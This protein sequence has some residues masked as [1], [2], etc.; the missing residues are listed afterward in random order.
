M[1]QTPKSR[2]PREALT[3]KPRSPFV[4]DLRELGRQPGALRE[5]RR[6][7]TAK[8]TF[9]LDV[10]WVPAGAELDLD[11]RLESVTEGVLVTGTVSAPLTG[12]CARCLDP[13]TDELTVDVCELFAYAASS[14]DET[15]ERDEVY[16][17]EGERLDVEPV[18]RDAVVL[19][20][21]WTPL[22]AADC[23]GL[24]PDCGQRLDELPP[25]HAH[26]TIDPRWAALATLPAFTE[27]TPT[28]ADGS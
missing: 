12:Q 26:E 9:G 27:S 8:E 28:V 20:L 17:V 7:V 14:T 5:Y 15:T 11:L 4:F 23:A 18:V 19:D 25:D 22:C 13:I 24:C 10:I 21:P 16:R 1:P 3:T 6:Q 2:T